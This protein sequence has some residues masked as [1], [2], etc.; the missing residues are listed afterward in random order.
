MPSEPN[1]KQRK[2]KKLKR[3]LLPRGLSFTREGKVYVLV[4]L[5]V[6]FA[7]VNTGNNLLFLVL[8]LMLGLIVLSGIL[9]EVTLR[10]I[11]VRR[12]VP[13]RVDAG[14][15]FPVELALRNRKRWAASFSVELRDE[16]DGKA[17]RRR[18]FFLRVGPGEE[19]SIAYRCEIA[20]RGRA[21]FDG[22]IVSTRFPFGLFE[23][24]RFIELVD[25]LLVLPSRVPVRAPRAAFA[26]GDG[27]RTAGFRG[28]GQDFL[29]LRQMVPGDDPRL[30]HWPGSA[31]LGQLLVKETER[32]ARGFVEI[33]LDA[34]PEKDV[35][36][37]D[38]AVEQNIR[39]AGTLVRDL[40]G[41]GLTV[42]LTTAEGG[43]LETQGRPGA[44]PLLDHLALLEP[45]VAV[46]RDPPQARGPG[47]VLIGPR[48]RAAGPSVRLRVPPPAPADGGGA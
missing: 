32:D 38:E 3:W 43:S 26:P 10:E 23:K 35:D 28:A 36:R 27:G 39:A 34:A 15:T 45:E 48:A 16:I 14:A 31:R 18:C 9:S 42:R 33:V 22:T 13:P 12:S 29:E 11:E 21:R 6:G 25:E 44:I 40:S 1:D 37:A 20:Q 5:G 30:I 4:T 2:R 8:G 19:R 7:A 17:F 46:Q 47:A 24:N 41:R